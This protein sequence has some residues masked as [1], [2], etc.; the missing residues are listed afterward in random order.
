M[1]KIDRILT[2][3]INNGIP[4]REKTEEIKNRILST[5]VS[6]DPFVI[7]RMVAAIYNNAFRI[8]NQGSTV[9]KNK[10]FEI[11]PKLG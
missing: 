2:G 3:L 10:R 1:D 4:S 11:F 5:S 6:N 7:Y 9:F 8:C